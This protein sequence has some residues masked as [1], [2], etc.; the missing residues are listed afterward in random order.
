MF[1]NSTK[2]GIKAV[3]YL[4]VHSSED[5]KI[6]IKDIAEPINVP[7]HYIAKILQTL[8]KRNLISSHK[9]PNGGFYLSEENRQVKVSDIVTAIDG[10]ER[11]NSCLLSLNECD[12]T[13]PCSLHHLIFNEKQKI[14]D[15]LDNTSLQDL[16]E[17]IKKGKSVLPL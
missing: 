5:Q 8:S 3:L 7:R 14:L 6:M 2:Y 12:S 10:E 9:G 11:I 15:R 4:A 17:H 16:A 13:N 1:S